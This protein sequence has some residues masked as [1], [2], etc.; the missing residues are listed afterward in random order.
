MLL[1]QNLLL[2]HTNELTDRLPKQQDEAAGKLSRAGKQVHR[3]IL[4]FVWR[5]VVVIVEHAA[6]SEPKLVPFPPE[7]RTRESRELW[8]FQVRSATVKA[9][10]AARGSVIAHSPNTLSM[11]YKRR[12]IRDD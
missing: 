7:R 2:Q 10:N 4:T 5:V 8:P 1:L 6:A 9:E 3:L 11:V 12:L